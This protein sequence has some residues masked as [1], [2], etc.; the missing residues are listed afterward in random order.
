[1][2]YNQGLAVGLA[3]GLPCFLV[4][5]IFL[6]F[7]AR[8]R[9]R[10]REEDETGNDLD[11]ELRDTKLFND[12]QE[13][14]HQQREPH[15]ANNGETNI[16]AH[17]QDSSVDE[18]DRH[19]HHNKEVE[20]ALTE[21]SSL[22][23]LLLQTY[24]E[25]R[26]P[27]LASVPQPRTPTRTPTPSMKNNLRHYKTGSSYDFYEQFIPVIPQQESSDLLQPPQVLGDGVSVHSTGNASVGGNSNSANASRHSLDT[28]AKQLQAPMMF[29]KLPSRVASQH[30]KNRLP[31]HN[32]NSSSEILPNGQEKSNINDSYAFS[33][34][35]PRQRHPYHQVAGNT[36]GGAMGNLEANFDND[37]AADVHDEETPDV[38]FK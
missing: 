33:D 15:P 19:L 10:Q 26:G 35:L 3:V 34:G 32:N 2:A 17:N 27:T 6:V 16:A 38:I 36:I 4:L 18:N 24:L 20:K 25:K 9:R 29:P 22:G 12:F 5:C 28:L 21:E 31:L 37:V 30:M 8:H 11:L 23:H 14:L 13:E 1:M 7:Y